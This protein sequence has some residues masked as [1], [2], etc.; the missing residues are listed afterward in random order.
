M[1]PTLQKRYLK[2]PRPLPLHLALQTLTLTSSLSALPLLKNGLPGLNHDLQ[3]RLEKLQKSL[4]GIPQEQFADAVSKEASY[5]Q[6]EFSKGVANYQRST[7]SNRMPTPPVVWEEG[8]ARLLDYGFPEGRHGNLPPVLVIPSLIN[9]AYILDLIESRS[10]MRDMAQQGLHPY[11]IDWDAPGSCENEYSVGDYISGPLE[12][13]LEVVFRRHDRRVSVVGYCMGGLLA[14]ALCVTKPDYIS[15]LVLLATPWDFHQGTE[16]SLPIL[17]ALRPAYEAL[18]TTLGHLP[19]DAI[20]AMF[21]GLDPFLTIKKFRKFATPQANAERTRLFI[22]L[23]DWINDGVP[24]TVGVAR[25]CLFD[26][27]VENKTAENLWRVGGHTIIPAKIKHPVLAV[28]PE[29]D[30][31]V[32]PKSALALYQALPNATKWML[33]S[34]HIGMISGGRAKKTLYRPLAG[35]LLAPETTR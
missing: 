28:I 3:E 16:A 18:L 13:A 34:G 35:W 25:E 27:Y 20:Q 8:N 22:A 14:T 4:E 19:V 26:W 23:E 9:R 7:G 29:N 15:R 6:G 32:P 2:A 30:H 10:F 31:I 17:K 33:P 12:N 24:L 11:L 1:Q 21:T 5:R